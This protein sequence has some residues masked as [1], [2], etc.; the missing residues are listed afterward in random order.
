MQ[1]PY[2]ASGNQHSLFPPKKRNEQ[3]FEGSSSVLEKVT[4]L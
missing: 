2:Y 3:I 1:Q 4:I